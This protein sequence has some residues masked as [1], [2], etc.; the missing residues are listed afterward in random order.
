MITKR[1]ISGIPNKPGVYIFK[2][3]ET[4]IYIGKAKDLKK[5]ILQHLNAKEGKSVFI[6][7]EATKIDFIVTSNEKEALILEANLIHH[8]KPK[9]NTLLKSTEVYPYIRISEGKFP[10]VEVVRRKGK[11]GEFYGPFTNVRFTRELLE[12]LQQFLKFRTCKKKLERI[13]RPCMDFHIG[14]CVGPCVPGRVSE[15]EYGRI[16]DELRK[17]LKG[18]VGE[19]VEKVRKKME[20]HAKMLDF[21]NAA[22]YRDVLMR[23]NEILQR[24]GVN[25]PDGRN[26]DVVVGED[27]LFVVLRIRGGFLLGKLVYEMEGASLDEFVEMFYAREGDLPPKVVS[28]SSFITTITPVLSPSDGHE[29]K[30]LEIAKENLEEEL[31][32]RGM[33]RD[34][35]KRLAEF[36]GLKE[37]RRIEGIDISHLMG[38]GTVASL[39]VFIDGKPAKEEYR[40]Y[41]VDLKKPDDY[42]AIKEVVRRRYSKHEVPDLLFVD[43]G[44]GQV[45]A[46]LHGLKLAG[47]SCKVV[48]LAKSE[49]RVVREDGEFKLPLDSPVVRALVMVRDEA[50]RFALEGSRRVRMKES[51]KSILQQVEGIGPVR[52]R[53]LL[54]RFK[55]AE[56]LS[57][58][59][60]DE[61]AQ[62][63]GSRKVAERI[64][65]MI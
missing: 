43:G 58:A 49:E 53:K 27:G 26:L 52:R 22:R 11:S 24:Q 7:Q 25:L 33:R 28:E 54:E 59:S 34:M 9:Y 32:M 64:K 4:P 10:Y 65:E 36:V 48:G 60:V 57:R 61:I 40:R 45:K 38:K 3:G 15:E 14:R 39:V 17:F 6:V 55:S 51:L 50:H 16:I 47:K 29:E 31:R 62:V 21:E 42:R 20:R 5:R 23:M 30:L 35:L 44:K 63:V 56:E 19:F 13:K 46:A 41:R 12:I 1:E 2:N 8:H 18:E 37:I